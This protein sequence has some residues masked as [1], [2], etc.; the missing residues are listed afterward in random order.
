MDKNRLDFDVIQ[1]FLKNHSYWANTRP[2]TN[3]TPASAL[4]RTMY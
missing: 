3:S 4:H 1:D 2:P